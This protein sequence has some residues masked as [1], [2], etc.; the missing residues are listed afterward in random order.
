MLVDLLRRNFLRCNG[1]FFFSWWKCKRIM[2]G[3]RTPCMRCEFWFSNDAVKCLMTQKRSEQTKRQISDKWTNLHQCDTKTSELKTRNG[4]KET[5]SVLVQAK[6]VCW[7]LYTRSLV[8]VLT[9]V[10]LFT[11]RKFL[12]NTSKQSDFTTEIAPPRNQ[13]QPETICLCGWED[14]KCKR[15]QEKRCAQSTSIWTVWCCHLE[16]KVTVVFL[17][18]EVT[19]DK[20]WSYNDLSANHAK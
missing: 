13:N 9:E 3:K 2:K 12:F 8:Q 10:I 16:V 7:L 1:D 11:H 14:H 19:S 18:L 17:Q 6:N 5:F 15:R 4:T 20:F